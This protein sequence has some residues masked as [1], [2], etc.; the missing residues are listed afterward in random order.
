[1]SFLAVGGTLLAGGALT[2]GTVAAGTALAGV[3][4]SIYSAS[5]QKKATNKAL[6][7]QRSIAD[8]VRYE[9][10]DIESLKASAQKNAIENATNSLALERQLTPDVAALRDQ[11]NATKLELA[12]QVDEDL[13]LGGNLSPDVINRVQTAGRLV[14]AKSGIGSPSAVPLTASLLG[15]ESINLMN[16]RRNAANSLAGPG[17]LPTAGLDPGTLASLEVADNA[18]NNQFNL[19]KAGVSSNL[20]NSEAAARSAQIGGQVGM[21]SSLA[22]LLGQGIGGYVNSRA[23]SPLYTPVDTKFSF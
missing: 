21:A 18:A 14:G 11:T 7:A 9:P 20:A 2:A 17:E 8:S 22:N 23:K 15:I 4:T 19:E 5:Q 10:I 12:R 6:D 3:G 16:S 13:R 1:M